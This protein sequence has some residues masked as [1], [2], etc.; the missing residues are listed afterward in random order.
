VTDPTPTVPETLREDSGVDG[1]PSYLRPMPP[2]GIYETLYAFQDAFGKPMGEPDTHPWSQGYPRTEQI[3]GG[4]KMPSTITVSSEDRLYPKSWGLPALRQQI[5][6]YYCQ[7][8]GASIDA[9]N[10]M[11]FAGGRP[12]LLSV[13]L[14]LQK[15]IGVKIAS[16]EYTPYYDILERLAVPYDLIESDVEN[17]FCPPIGEYT[18]KGTH[19]RTMMMMSNPCNPTGITRTGADIDALVAAASTPDCGLLIDEAYELFHDPPFSALAHVEDIDQ[20][21]IFVIGAATKGLQS[22]GIRIGWA[23]AARHHIEILGNFSSF[24]MGGVSHPSQC[25]ALELL[26]PERIEQV[27]SA[28]PTFYGS[29][30]QRYGEAFEKLG[31]RLFTG[32]GGFYHWCQLPGGMTAAELNGRLFPAGAA[33]LKGNDCDMRRF[34][35][36]SP[37]RNFFRFSFGPLAPESFEEDIKILARALQI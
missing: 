29:Q 17:R 20:T 16:T 34:G 23:I 30:R 3:P 37:L 21:N 11:V 35:S 15:G 1:G 32:D 6:S 27:R 12:A 10:V 4:P 7:H 22:P 13:L 5:A 14:F 8:Y 33:I 25:Y 24:G 2:M 31:L 28:V 9:K 18:T 36:L 26:A 19:D